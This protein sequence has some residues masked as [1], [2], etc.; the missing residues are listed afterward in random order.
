MQASQ[1]RRHQALV[2]EQGT[3]RIELDY[4]PVSVE[5]G[6]S[7]HVKDACEAGQTVARQIEASTQSADIPVRLSSF[8]VNPTRAL[9]AHSS[10]CLLLWLS[11][12]SWLQ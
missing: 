12:H 9:I 4:N 1:S 5:L 10:S 7:N 6:I 11:W 3:Q 8:C 2:N